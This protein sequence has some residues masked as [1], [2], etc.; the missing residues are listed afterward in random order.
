MEFVYDDGGREAAGYKGDAGDCVCRA[1]TI[2]TGLPY[3]EVYD[4]LAEGNATQRKGK[5]A[6]SKDGVRTA[7]KG[8]NTNRKWFKDYMQSLGFKWVP[9]M[10]VGQ[11][12]KVHLCKEELPKG[13][14]IVAVSKHYTVVIDGVIHDTHNP[15]ERGVTV[16]PPT[17]PKDQLP[18]GAYWMENGNGWAYAPQRCVY[19]YYYRDENN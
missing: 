1:I 13:K 3:K 5:R 19:G 15:S 6:K 17:Y 2:V 12:C 16:Y 14:L 10:L 7:A 8:I 11:G 4:R 9:T 18:K